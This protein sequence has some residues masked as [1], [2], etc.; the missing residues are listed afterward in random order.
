MGFEYRLRFAHTG[1]EGF[2]AVLRRLPQLRA[3]APPGAFELRRPGSSKGPPE[4]TLQLEPDGAY[5][6]WYSVAGREFLGTLVTNLVSEFGAV[7]VEDR[8]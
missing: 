5:Y 4:A 6:C 8:E 3:I 7:T 1:S 2:A